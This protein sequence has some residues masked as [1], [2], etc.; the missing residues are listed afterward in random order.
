MNTVDKTNQL[1][2]RRAPVPVIPRQTPS[3]D[4]MG[5]RSGKNYLYDGIQRDRNQGDVLTALKGNPYALSII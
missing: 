1:S 3:I 4:N 2:N 5:Q